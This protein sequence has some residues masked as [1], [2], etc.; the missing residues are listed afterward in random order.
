MRYFD[1][2]L[3]EVPEELC[4]RLGYKK[5]Y[6]CGKDLF[7]NRR[8]VKAQGLQIIIS[9]DPGVL[10]GALKDSSVVGI[11][12]EEDELAKR[13]VEKAAELKK[14]IFIP[15]GGVVG[16]DAQRRSVKVN[17]IRKIIF[18]THKSK[19]NANL[20]TLAESKYQLQS[21]AQMSEIGHLLLGG[22]D[23]SS[24]VRDEAL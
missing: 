9:K 12:F 11:I 23:G 2:A 5:I 4:R 21:A 14:T 20:V 16:S 24:L 22:L 19:A 1:I 3:C 7:I 13:V 18:S 17:K 10:M 6:C 15:I 8:P